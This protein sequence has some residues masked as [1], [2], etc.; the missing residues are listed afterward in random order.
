MKKVIAIAMALS[1]MATPASAVTTGNWDMGAAN[2]SAA[3][4]ATKLWQEQQNNKV[5]EQKVEEHEIAQPVL[6]DW[7]MELIHA[8]R[9]W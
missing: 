9:W 5:E 4:A 6:P 7:I 3:N 2:Q 1:M 8:W